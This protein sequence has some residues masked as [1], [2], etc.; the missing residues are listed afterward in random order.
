MDV[1]EVPDHRTQLKAL[2]TAFELAGALPG[3]G[4]ARKRSEHEGIQVIVAPP[5]DGADKP[6]DPQRPPPKTSPTEAPKV[7]SDLRSADEANL[8]DPTPGD[9]NRPRKK[10]LVRN[11]EMEGYEWPGWG[12]L[13][14]REP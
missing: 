3:K 5:A 4:P 6:L 13:R 7:A 11:P 10:P 1:Y 9:F 12:N 14:R 8:S 2:R